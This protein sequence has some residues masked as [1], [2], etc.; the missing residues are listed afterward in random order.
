MTDMAEF[1]TRPEFIITMLAAISAFAT[2]LTIALP[3]LERDRI[4]Q[5]MKVMAIERDKMRAS[6]LAEISTK[7][8]KVALRQAPKGYMQRV[9]DMLDL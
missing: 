1:V 9:V 3:L 6:R 7:D 4:G 2:V 5:R 8:G